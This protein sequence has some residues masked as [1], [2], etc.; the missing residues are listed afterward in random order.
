[1][2]FNQFFAADHQLMITRATVRADVMCH[3]N[4]NSTDWKLNIVVTMSR[5]LPK[6]RQKPQ[7]TRHRSMTQSKPINSRCQSK[8][9]AQMTQKSHW[10][11]MTIS[12]GPHTHTHKKS[13][14]TGLSVT[15][16]FRSDPGQWHVAELLKIF[17]A[18]HPLRRSAPPR[19][20]TQSNSV[21]SR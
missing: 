17:P 15:V 10:S 9:P 18:C 11:S 13:H 3:F 14:K 6:K 8:H 5:K 20:V 4:F 19:S 2:K 1:M 16:P 21:P 7:I 12:R